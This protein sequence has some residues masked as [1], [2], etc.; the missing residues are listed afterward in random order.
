MRLVVFFCKICK[1]L[2]TICLPETLRSEVN[3]LFDVN[4]MDVAKKNK[5]IN[6]LSK[7][8]QEQGSSSK[9]LDAKGGMFDRLGLCGLL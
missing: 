9:K 1:R 7:K 2:S 4:R 8:L 3:R 5:Q 6:E